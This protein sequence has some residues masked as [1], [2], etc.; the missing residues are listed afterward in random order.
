MCQMDELINVSK[1]L[2]NENIT[3]N[4][5]QT[6]LKQKELIKSKLRHEYEQRLQLVNETIQSLTIT[7]E[8]N[9]VTSANGRKNSLIAVDNHHYNIITTIANYHV[10]P[11]K[12]L[13][14][15]NGDLMQ[16]GS[17]NSN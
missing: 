10:T 13:K 14:K 5:I 6:I 11:N 16:D 1:Y 4:H 12:K 8:S 15:D 2:P 3:S 9:R 17:I 7:D